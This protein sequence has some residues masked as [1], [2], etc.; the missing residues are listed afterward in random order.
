MYAA[1][2]PVVDRLAQ[3]LGPAWVVCDGV[4]PQDRQHLPR[5]DVRLTDAAVTQKSGGGVALAVRYTVRIAVDIGVVTP[6]PLAALDSAVKTIIE[7]LHQYR[8][9]PA[10]APLE[11]LSLAAAEYVD[12]GLFGYD[13]EFSRLALVQSRQA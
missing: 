3:E 13:I 7:V 10:A 11:L 1:I 8:P 4:R 5:A 12:A 9:L 2:T 6:D